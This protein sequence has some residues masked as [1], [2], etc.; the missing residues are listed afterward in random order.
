[1]FDQIISLSTVCFL[2]IYSPLCKKKKKKDK[3]GKKKG[4]EIWSLA[5]RICVD[6]HRLLRIMFF[7]VPG[8]HPGLLFQVFPVTVPRAYRSLLPFDP[9]CAVTGNLV[10]ILGSLK[11]A[12]LQGRNGEDKSQTM[13]CSGGGG[14]GA[15]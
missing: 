7:V 8:R 3:A 9:N 2:I 1:M 10:F 13:L 14:G 4:R 5:S 6:S 11:E 12:T 15:I